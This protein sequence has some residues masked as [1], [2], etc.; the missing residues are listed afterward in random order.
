M[1]KLFNSFA[2]FCILNLTLNDKIELEN[3]LE[4]G[5]IMKKVLNK[6]PFENILIS[7]GLFL[8]ILCKLIT[9]KGVGMFSHVELANF[10]TA[11]KALAPAFVVMSLYY[12]MDSLEHKKK[13][14][15]QFVLI[16]LTSLA[17]VVPVTIVSM[18]IDIRMISLKNIIKLFFPFLYRNYFFLGIFFLIILIAPL[19]T[20]K[21]R[22]LNSQSKKRVIILSLIFG[23][24]ASVFLVKHPSI[25]MLIWTTIACCVSLID[26]KIFTKKMIFYCVTLVGVL[27]LVGTFT[28]EAYRFSLISNLAPLFTII[29][30]MV[31]KKTSGASKKYK[32]NKN[33]ILLPLVLVF[34]N[35]LLIRLSSNFYSEYFRPIQTG[36]I[37][38][39]GIAT[40]TFIMVY[41]YNYSISKSVNEIYDDRKISVKASVPLTIIFVSIMY[42]I[43]NYSEFFALGFDAMLKQQGGR[44]YLAFLNLLLVTLWFLVVAAIINRFWISTT[45]FGIIMISL[46]VANIQKIQYRNEPVIYPDLAM[47]KSLPEIVKMVN[48]N[49]VILILMAFLVLL[50]LAFFLQKKILKGKLFKFTPRVIIFVFSGFLLW[51]F[52]VV[53]NQMNLNAWLNKKDDMKNPIANMIVTAGYTAHPENLG[54]N[55]QAY[56]PALVFTSTEI[57]KTMDKPSDYSK[58]SVNKIVSKYTKI[59]NALNKKRKFDNLNNQ[60][61]IYI[62]S[63]S[64]ADPRR[65]PSVKLSMDPTPYMQTM[66]NKN[67]SGLMFSSGYGGGTA[68][69]E[70][71]ALTSLSMNNFDPSLVTPYVFLVP[72]VNNLPVVTDLFTHKNAIHPYES[73]TYDR[74]KVFKKFGFQSFHTLDNKNIDFKTKLGKSVYVDDQSAFVQ[75]LKQ[76]NSVKGGQ[77]IQLSTMQNHMPYKKGT[78]DRNDFH[79]TADLDKTSI[80]QIESYTQGIHYS[81]SALKNFVAKINEMKKHITIVFYGD[82][83]P[84]IYS[85]N[86]VTGKNAVASEGKLHQTDY[87]IYSNF[88]THKVTNTNIVSPNMFTPMVLEKLNEKVSPYYALLTLVQKRV[89]AGELNKFMKEN[90]K[91]IPE[92]ELSK[93]SKRVLRDYKLI[94]YDITAGSQYS[95]KT[96]N[97]VK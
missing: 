1:S 84:G 71:E 40:L 9:N 79:V 78:Y 93:R 56:G 26:T 39:I 15:R 65:V 34:T 94:Q 76:I 50:I 47:I 33:F 2:Q 8:A 59:A 88:H 92:K 3:Y 72:R 49:L 41:G 16:Y 27:I 77:F 48:V 81:D 97:F 67:P 55:A 83:L 68:N 14:I 70:F 46:S 38:F 53:E 64:Y 85:G 13:S 89:P 43:Y 35:P 96:K 87:F 36:W 42:I 30:S 58:K 44:I 66:K 52:S 18:A 75:T 28:S 73:T 5:K 12:V 80:S 21:L 20:E 32:R 22:K 57:I 91:L 45:I 4:R 54:H 11:F 10:I 25:S 29:I 82:H 63:E 95:L 61:V 74:G 7:G 6:I 31:A 24:I 37:V 69:I 19:A 90:G 23:T 51:Q 17:A 86:A 60:T 62:L